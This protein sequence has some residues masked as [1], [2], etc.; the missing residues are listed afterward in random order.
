MPA[1]SRAGDPAPEA[2]YPPLRR[3]FH[4]QIAEEIVVPLGLGLLGASLLSLVGWGEQEM[5]RGLNAVTIIC[6]AVVLAMVAWAIFGLARRQRP[7]PRRWLLLATTLGLFAAVVDGFGAF[8]HATASIDS[9][10]MTLWGY[11]RL[12]DPLH[13]V[14]LLLG[15]RTLHPMP[16]WWGWLWW[17]ALTATLVPAA[18]LVL[19]VLPLTLSAMLVAPL[20]LLGAAGPFARV[21][22]V[23]LLCSALRPRQPSAAPVD[24][25]PRP[26]AS[27]EAASEP[28]RD[29]RLLA[30]DAPRAALMRLFW[31]LLALGAVSTW[32]GIVTTVAGGLALAGFAAIVVVLLVRLGRQLPIPAARLALRWAAVCLGLSAALQ[33]GQAGWLDL[34]WEVAALALRALGY[35]LLVAALRQITELPGWWQTVRRIALVVFAL[36]PLARA[37]F[38]LFAAGETPPMLS[39]MVLVTALFASVPLLLLLV[40]GVALVLHQRGPD[41]RLA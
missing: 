16:R 13:R 28:P 40:G 21:A 17:G 20:A 2:L 8:G 11:L 9:L 15:L 38:L 12:A 3:L 41:D 22:L 1:M 26:E 19:A 7:G 39:G 27:T 32:S 24:A 5:L 31:G 10:A 4:L 14:F 37:S 6:G 23:G 35:G 33:L 30:P 25:D 18:A 29:E 36:M 34:W